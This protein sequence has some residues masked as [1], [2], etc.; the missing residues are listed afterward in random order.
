MKS[1][2]SFFL[3][4]ALF[5]VSV[6][7]VFAQQGKPLAVDSLIVKA[8]EN[9][10]WIPFMES[11]R[12]LN[13]EQLKSIHASEITRVSVP[14]NQIESGD[15]YWKTMGS[16]F[17]QI[18]K[19]KYQ[20]NIRFSIVSSATSTDKV[21]QTGYYTIGL[22]ANEQSPY[23]STGY[24]SFTIL[25]IKDAADGKWKITFDSDAPLQITEEEFQKGIVYE[26]N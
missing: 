13:F 7:T 15:D 17:E 9:D 10:I 19:M 4:I 16:F 23:Q 21:Y 1:F 11:Y 5:F 6:S 14:M 18:Q 24:S 2:C 8:V 3:V 22:K 12:D 25:A 26:L 20:M